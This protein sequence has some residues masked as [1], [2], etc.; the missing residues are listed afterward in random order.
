[1]YIDKILEFN[2]ELEQ[3]S[4]KNP[5]KFMEVIDALASIYT[6]VHVLSDQKLIDTEGIFERLVTQEQ[7]ELF[8][9]YING[10]AGEA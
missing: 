5:K 1:M 10:E 9:N 3:L 7:D 6:A 8:T 2:A 4:Q